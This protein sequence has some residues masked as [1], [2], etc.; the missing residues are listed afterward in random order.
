MRFFKPLLMIVFST[1]LFSQE[2]SVQEKLAQIVDRHSKF[3]FNMGVLLHADLNGTVYRIQEG[4]ANREKKLLIKITDP[5]QIGSSSKVFTGVAIFQLIEAGKLSLDTKISTFYP[6]GSN[7]WKL[8]NFKG[9]NYFDQVTVGMLLN[10][11]SGF[12][13]YLNVYNDDKKAME[14]YGKKQQYSFNE[15]INLAVNFGD[16]NFKPGTQ[17][18]YCN[19]GYTILGDIITKV[20]GMNWRD[21]IQAHIFDALSLKQTWF[22]SR[23]PQTAA[24]QMPQGYFEL[25]PSFMPPTLA[26]SAGEIVSTVDDIATFIKAWGEGKL[27]KKSETLHTQ[28]TQGFHQM[29]PGI[30]N[31]TYGYAIMH[32]GN[33]YGHGGQTFGFQSYM[34]TDPKTH[35]TITIGVNDAM[36]HAMELFMDVTD[37]VFISAKKKETDTH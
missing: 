15:L 25:Q 19:T 34:M 35:D 28:L 9:K 16:A 33:Y 12:I 31:L 5:F 32:F 22:G 3:H 27:Y 6:K 14:I 7:V 8:G 23:L 29:S 17:F 1:L 24:A 13:D 30:T 21:Y 2:T 37:T 36:G 10:H 11:T 4:Y 20:S 18:K 26:G